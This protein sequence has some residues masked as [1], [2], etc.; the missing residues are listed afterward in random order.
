MLSIGDFA[1]YA[2]V[3]VRM[4]RHYD[5]EGLLVPARVD[6]VTGY[7]SYAAAQLPRINRL[8]ALKELGFHLDEVGRILDG[9]LAAD[10]LRG[11]LRLRQT[12]LSARIEADRA[13]LTEVA[14]RLRTI[15]SEGTMSEIEY[16]EKALPA[17][18]LAQ[19]STSVPSYE[20]VGPEVGPLFGRLGT[21]LGRAGVPMP[22]P[23][24]A[25]YVGNEDGLT[26]GVGWATTRAAVD[27]EGVEVADL[28]AYDRALTTIHRGSMERIG[29]AW[30]ALAGEVEARGLRFGGPCREVYHH[31]D[32]TN[33]EAW[34]TELQQPVA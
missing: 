9:G 26:L 18:R 33:H 11:M 24:L 3:S 5:A 25:W 28:A 6:P 17:V 14:A 12:E 19:L 21:L 20:K 13:R 1:R 2:G 22:E 32:P 27:V 31:V 7:R 34:V 16:V 8:V 4:L 10:E 30:Q 29:S 23:A 15:E